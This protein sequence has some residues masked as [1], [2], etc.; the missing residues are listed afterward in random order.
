MG[1]TNGNGMGMKTRLNLGMRMGIGM[2]HWEWE[3]M[4]LK[5]IPARLYPRPVW[6]LITL[7][8]R[9]SLPR[10]PSAVAAAKPT[11]IELAVGNSL[12]DTV[13]CVDHAHFRHRHI[14][15]LISDVHSSRI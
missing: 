3:G 2:N 10:C 7:R 12:A 13:A 15:E 1:I 4:A 5:V 8:A 11:C 6:G 14:P 9:G